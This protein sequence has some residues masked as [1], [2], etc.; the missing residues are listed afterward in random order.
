MKAVYLPAALAVIA[1][2][3]IAH[4]QEGE[5]NSLSGVKVGVEVTRDSNQV[6]QAGGTVDATRHGFGVR[7]FAGYDAAIGK[8]VIVGAEIGIGKGGR[9]SDQA[10]LVAPGRYSVDPGFTYDMTARAGV[11]PT[12]G[13]LL[14]GRAGYRWLETKQSIAGQAT[15]NV[16]TKVTEKGFTYGGGIE[17]ALSQNIGLRAE[18][19]RTNYDRNFTQN[20]VSVGA[21]FRF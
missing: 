16:D 4:A 2:P 9:T 20:K 14:Y 3:T 13:L 6:R 1:L 17:Y 8:M 15:G 12:S 21:S 11:I 19:N 18:F 5:R 7:G 10:S